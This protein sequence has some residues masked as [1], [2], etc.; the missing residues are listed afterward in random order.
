MGDQNKAILI[1]LASR[2]S[3]Y[4]II[5]NTLLAKFC[6][7]ELLSICLKN[8]AT[9]EYLMEFCDSR[10]KSYSIGIR[11][12]TDRFLLVRSSPRYDLDEV[13]YKMES[14]EDVDYLISK[15]KSYHYGSE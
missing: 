6:V 9:N 5:K 11:I 13:S 10:P 15:L 8:D 7:K 2:G 3:I 4:V 14:L 12:T 1:Q